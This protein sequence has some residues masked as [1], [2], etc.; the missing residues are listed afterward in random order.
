MV[1]EIKKISLYKKDP[2]SG[3]LIPHEFLVENVLLLFAKQTKL[4]V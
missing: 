4:I 3:G 2:K 1:N